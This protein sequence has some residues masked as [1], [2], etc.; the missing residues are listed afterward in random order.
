MAFVFQSSAI[1]SATPQAQL[2][3]T[4]RRHRAPSPS[5][6]PDSDDGVPSW[7]HSSSSN[8][9]PSNKRQKLDDGRDHSISPLVAAQADQSSW[10]FVASPH[11]SLSLNTST[12][13]PTPESTPPSSSVSSASSSSSSSSSSASS[14]SDASSVCSDETSATEVEG[15]VVDDALLAARKSQIQL[16]QIVNAQKDKFVAGLVGASIVAL[17]SI[18]GSHS[19]GGSSSHCSM[20]KDESS[21]LPLQYFIK[22]VLRRSRTSCSTLQVALYYLHKSR[23]EIRAAIARC[24]TEAKEKRDR[25]D[26]E[27]YPSPP[28]T[29]RESLEDLLGRRKDGSNSS[30]EDSSDA[31][32]AS[33]VLCGRRMFLSALITASKF[34]QDKNYSNRAWAKI[35]GLSPREITKNERCFLGILGWECFVGATEFDLWTERLSA[36][37]VNTVHNHASAVQRATSSSSLPIARPLSHATAHHG[38]KAKGIARSATEYPAIPTSSI[39]SLRAQGRPVVV[40]AP[41]V[42]DVGASVASGIFCAP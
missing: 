30:Q 26:R 31:A 35:S 9:S 11:D 23:R 36:L 22:E 41:S 32:G 29:P 7:H 18:W 8:I 4:R 40:R 1:S 14:S 34:L 17:E 6:S 37:A 42:P 2:S 10:Q 3:A 27:G 38:L 13:L 28:L 16:N 39:E 12:L 19:N 5:S 33:P 20:A 15:E 21:V 25:E 24:A